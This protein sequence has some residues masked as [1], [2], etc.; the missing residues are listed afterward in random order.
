MWLVS[1]SSLGIAHKLEYKLALSPDAEPKY[2]GHG[3]VVCGVLCVSYMMH[4]LREP[5]YDADV[6]A[7]HEAAVATRPRACTVGFVE[8][9][10]RSM[11]CLRKPQVL[12]PYIHDDTEIII[13]ALAR[14]HCLPFEHTALDMSTGYGVEVNDGGPPAATAF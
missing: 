8:Y 14:R 2:D 9:E 3:A 12:S 5:T 4:D 11:C 1:D 13:A 7:L 10:T 6:A